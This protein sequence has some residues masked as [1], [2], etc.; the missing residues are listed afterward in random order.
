MPEHASSL[1]HTATI[2]ALESV[3][4]TTVAL[5][6]D[7]PAELPVPTC[8]G[9]DATTALWTH[10]G[11]V[12]RW[13]AEI[14][15]TRS[16]VRIAFRDIALHLPEDGMWAPWLADG[17]DVLLAALRDTAGDEPMWVW[18][19]DPLGTWWARR[20]LHETIVH[21]ADAAL[22]LGRGS[23]CGPSSP[24]TASTSCSTTRRRAC[25]GGAGK[26]PP[27]PTLTAHLHATDG[28]PGPTPIPVPGSGW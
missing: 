18:A 12:H 9:W 24:P 3:L 27:L 8:P 14:V 10:L 16:D 6:A 19:D 13:A 1:D 22:A 7:T 23:T 28:V 5:A 26:A 2:D 11:T 25:P 15:A 17:A 20:Q 4:A 21:N